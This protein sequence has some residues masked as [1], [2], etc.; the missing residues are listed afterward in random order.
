MISGF[1]LL[2]NK[3]NESY[4]TFYRK[5][6][7]KIIIPLVFWALF[8]SCLRVYTGRINTPY[9]FFMNILSGKPYYHLWF[10]Y[11]I[12]PLYL[13][14]PFLRKW[15]NHLNTKELFILILLMFVIASSAILVQN[16]FS[17]TND[18]FFTWFFFFLPYFFTGFLLRNYN[19]TINI[20]YLCLTSLGSII[21]IFIGSYILPQQSNFNHGLYFLVS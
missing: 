16:K 6:M 11:M 9:E 8:Y 5:R 13:F 3:P 12:I 4:Q 19:N 1:F 18:L 7:N 10:L 21:I 15:V 14:T 17:P 20:C 2:N